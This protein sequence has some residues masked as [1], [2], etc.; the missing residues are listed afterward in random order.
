MLLWAQNR[1]DFNMVPVATDSNMADINAKP[2]GGQRIRFMMNL[3]G[4]WRNEEQTRGELER[5]AY[6][7]RKNFAGKVNKIAKRMVRIVTFEGLQPMVTEAYYLH[8][9]S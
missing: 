8:E 2:L 5:K 3:I 7:Q 4:C 9:R 1:K 6:E